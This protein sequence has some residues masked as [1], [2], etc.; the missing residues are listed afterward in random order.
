MNAK[1]VITGVSE[2]EKIAKE[3]LGHVEEI[4]RLQRIAAYQ[5]ISI[6]VEINEEAVRSV[7]DGLAD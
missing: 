2:A 4:G 3:I 5:G 1:I 6:Q 7:T